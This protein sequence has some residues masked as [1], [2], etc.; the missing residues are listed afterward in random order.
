MI[1]PVANSS[2]NNNQYFTAKTKKF[3]LPVQSYIYTID[4]IPLWS[5]RCNAIKEFS[6]P[7]AEELYKKAKKTKDLK[8]QARLYDEMGHYE[9]VD[10]NLREK[11]VSLFRALLP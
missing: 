4:G 7:D 5:K 9:L 6:N 2:I 10:M 1:L 3:R 11:F 8:E